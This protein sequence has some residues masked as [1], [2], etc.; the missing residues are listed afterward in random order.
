MLA[1]IVNFITI[2]SSCTKQL[3]QP[4]NE[5]SV[6]ETLNGAGLGTGDQ[7]F[8]TVPPPTPP[9]PKPDIIITAL[10]VSSVTTDHREGQ[11]HTPFRYISYTIKNAGT[12]KVSLN[13]IVLQGYYGHI[14]NGVVWYSTPGCGETA[15]Q[16]GP[17]LLPGASYS[18]GFICYGIGSNSSVY[19]KLI[20]DPY[21]TINELI[22]NNNSKYVAL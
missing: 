18:N 2:F 11:N 17:D 4:H 6:Q 7:D 19:Y 12:K 10:N 1:V 21:N 15:K 16:G 14:Y 20:A 9:T 13:D 22:E 8:E 3:Q 5:Q